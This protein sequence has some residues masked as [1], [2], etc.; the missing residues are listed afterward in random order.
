MSEQEQAQFVGCPNCGNEYP[1]IS[2]FAGKVLH[3]EGCDRKFVA[4]SAEAGQALIFP[5]DATP[6]GVVTMAALAS[7]EEDDFENDIR[8]PPEGVDPRLYELTVLSSATAGETCKFCG[9]AVMN[10]VAV[11]GR[12]GRNPE[13]GEEIEGMP[14][15]AWTAEKAKPEGGLSRFFRKIRVG[16]RRRRR[17]KN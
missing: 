4:A 15:A 3:C 12:C 1:W 13:T 6:R 11:C 10:G 9:A 7:T 8:K 5:E 17:K 16:M 2:S 14:Q